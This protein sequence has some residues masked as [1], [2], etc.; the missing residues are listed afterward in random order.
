MKAK[1]RCPICGRPPQP[2]QLPFCSRR[3]ANEDLGRWL[4]GAYRIA[5]EERAPG[6]APP[7]EPGIEDE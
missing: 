4:T 6:D 7:V 5:G 1:G 2:A 3:C